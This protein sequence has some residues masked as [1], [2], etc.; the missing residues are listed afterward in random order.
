MRHT[1]L[2]IAFALLSVAYAM[3]QDV[4]TMEEAVLGKDVAVQQFKW[5]WTLDKDIFA[6]G[7]Q[8]EAAKA[9]LPEAVCAQEV[10][11]HEFGIEQC[12]FYSPDSSRIAYYRNDDSRVTDYP[13][14]NIFSRT[15]D[16]RM[17][18][19]PMNGMPSERVSLNVYD[20]ATGKT[21]TLNVTDFDEERYLTNVTWNPAGDKIYVQVLDRAQ[22]HM[23]LNC[24]DALTGECLGTLI[25]E[26][27]PRFVEPQWPLFFLKNDPSKFIYTTD[28]RDGYK[29]LYICSVNG[30][31]PQRL[32]P[33]DAD[34]EYVAQ[35]GRYVYYYSAE[36]SP[37]ENHLFKVDLRNGKMTRLTPE[38]GWHECEFSPDMKYYMDSYSSLEVPRVVNL[39]SADGKRR[40]EV[41]RAP[42]PP[43]RATNCII[44]TGTVK[45]ADGRYDNYYSL[46]KPAD[47]D[48]TRK[49]PLILYVY[50]GP[51]NQLVQDR[52]Q[53]GI[54]RWE[55][56]MAQRG[57]VVFKMD[58]RGT[59]RRGAEYEK[60]IHKFCGRE[61]MADQ[62]EGIRWMMSKPWIDSERIGVHGWSYGGFMTISLMT[63][64]PDVFKVGVAGGPVIDWRWY[65]VM[66]GERY[67]ETEAT[68]PEGFA[69]TRLI[70]MAP[71][72]KGKLLI[73]QGVID[74]TVVWQHSLNFVE[75]CIK[76]NVQVDY[77]PY[78][79]HPHNVRGKDRVHLM[80]KVSNYLERYLA[81]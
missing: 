57:Y 60:A 25:T 23:H 9:A 32:T 35:D 72:L 59:P 50:G 56:L 48:S 47:F 75:S 8:K 70:P 78:P 43:E 38:K 10:S 29:N 77:F 33:V 12:V 4:M 44:E 34:V 7:R 6:P 11:R 71:E 1:I 42:M 62:M 30:G 3:A 49:Y 74:D 61:E 31:T 73:C 26:E 69:A 17:I 76:N 22:K 53:G 68:N 18:K 79:S 37:I 2:T 81:L 5:H 52:F 51:H 27:N 55:I 21:A 28:N 24:Y 63:N 36:V 64:Y 67:M 41:F 80:D 20:V 45:S 19:Y 13:L 65:E 54:S 15:G 46:V 58:N 16:V 66:Y 40:R 39:V 14:V